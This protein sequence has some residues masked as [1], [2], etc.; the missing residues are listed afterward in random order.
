MPTKA[1]TST[2]RAGRSS[3]PAPQRLGWERRT[4]RLCT[5]PIAHRRRHHATG[6]PCHR[7]TVLVSSE[8]PFAAHSRRPSSPFELGQLTRC[9]GHGPPPPRRRPPPFQRPFIVHLA[10]CSVQRAACAACT[11]VQILITASA[12][13]ELSGGYRGLVSFT[14][15]ASRGT[16]G[17]TMGLNQMKMA[18]FSCFYHIP[19]GFVKV[20]TVSI[21]GSSCETDQV[22]TSQIS[23]S[24]RPLSFPRLNFTTARIH[25]F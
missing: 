16:P 13:F 11:P 24:S 3:R 1:A 19:R 8:P 21:R 4:R 10:S 15:N 25:C 17:L 18:A 14:V 6:P 20:A 2:C 12:C 22:S 9:S 7:S 5:C 23:H